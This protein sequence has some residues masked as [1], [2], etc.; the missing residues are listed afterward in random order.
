MAIAGFLGYGLATGRL[1][2]EKRAQYAAIWQGEKLVR[3]VE[4]EAVVEEDTETPQA[5]KARISSAQEEREF[6]SRA[7]QRQ[8]QVLNN[9]K[10][11]IS[12]A[13]AKL[14]KDLSGLKVKRQAFDDMLAQQN[15]AAQ[16]KGFLKALKSYSS[17]NPKLVKNDFMEMD[18]KETVRYLAAMKSGTV[19]E[20]LS[21]FKIGRASCR[22][23]V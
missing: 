21:K 4:P 6:F 13:Q 19:T 10:V 11:S 8:I 22:E 5:A 23:R 14:D 18:E 20:I 12:A 15:A 2:A 3:Y 1:D 9:M 17:M 7:L 16:E